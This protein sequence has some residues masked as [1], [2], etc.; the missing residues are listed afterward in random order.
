MKSRIFHKTSRFCSKT[1][2]GILKSLP[3]DQ[4]SVKDFNLNKFHWPKSDLTLLMEYTTAHPDLEK[5]NAFA[6][7]IHMLKAEPKNN[8]SVEELIH[9]WCPSWIQTVSEMQDFAKWYYVNYESK[10]VPSVD[11][12]VNPDPVADE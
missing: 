5:F 4:F 6:Q 8:K 9:E 1:K 2:D 10:E 12:D 11:S 3:I 7:R